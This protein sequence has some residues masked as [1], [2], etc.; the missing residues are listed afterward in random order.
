MFTFS[1]KFITAAALSLSL[2]VTAIGTTT[3][4]A[5]ADNAEAAA[6]IGSII[7]LFAIAN[8]LD[9][10]NDRDERRVVRNN[11]RNNGHVVRNNHRNNARVIEPINQRRLVAPDRC[12]REFQTRNGTFNG[13]NRRCMQNNARNANLLP[14]RCLR[15]VRTDR[16][17]RNFYAGRCLRRN[18]WVRG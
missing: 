17:I 3:T 16:G 14:D 7:A 6:V 12:R 10:D 4:P 8:A 1:R 11:N 2:G 18:G 5:R 15:Q 9:N 13:Y